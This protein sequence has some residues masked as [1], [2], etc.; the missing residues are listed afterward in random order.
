MSA[1]FQLI[2]QNIFFIFKNFTTPDFTFGRYSLIW[3]WYLWMGLY[4][5]NKFWLYAEF[6][7]N[8][9][10]WA[11]KITRTK[12]PV[13]Q[14][15][16]CQTSNFP[17]GDDD[18]AA[19]QAPRQ[20]ISPTPNYTNFSCNLPNRNTAIYRNSNEDT[21]KAKQKNNCTTTNLLAWILF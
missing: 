16:Y 8:C 12:S 10:I 9:I 7:P 15:T 6:S 4:V 18:Y 19:F 1:A 13:L 5:S 2:K 14:T 11:Y 17:T 20:T 3:W 21:H